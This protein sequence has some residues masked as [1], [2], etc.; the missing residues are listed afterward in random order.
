MTQELGQIV[1]KSSMMTHDSDRLF[2]G[3][4]ISSDKAMEAVNK[5]LKEERIITQYKRYFLLL[6]NRKME[7]TLR[8]KVWEMLFFGIERGKQNQSCDDKIFFRLQIK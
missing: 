1:Y 2:V 5:L 8:P 4:P 6:E 3:V 7:G